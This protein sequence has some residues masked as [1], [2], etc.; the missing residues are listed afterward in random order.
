MRRLRN[1]FAAGALA[2]ALL[3]VM[4]PAA[5]ADTM[6]SRVGVATPMYPAVR[7][8]KSTI[9][10]IYSLTP[11]TAK[12]T[13]QIDGYW[14]KP[15]I[16]MTTMRG[17]APGNLVQQLKSYG[18]FTTCNPRTSNNCVNGPLHI[19]ALVGADEAAVDAV[20]P[21]VDAGTCTASETVECNGT[22]WSKSWLGTGQ[23]AIYSC[24]GSW[25][26]AAKG[27]D[28]S[29]SA[30]PRLAFGSDASG[31]G[32]GRPQSPRCD[33]PPVSGGAPTSIPGVVSWLAASGNR[34]AVADPA[35]DGFGEASKQAL[36]HNGFSWIDSG[37]GQNVF[38]GRACDSAGTACKVR[39]ESGSTQVRG[40]VTA[41]AG[42][43]TQLGLI[44]NSTL[45]NVN[46]TSSSLN[47]TTSH[48]PNTWTV[49]DWSD[50]GSGDIALA[51]FGVALN[52]DSMFEAGYSWGSLFVN[53]W[54][55]YNDIQTTLA[56]YGYV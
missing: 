36:I 51:R 3:A 52:A 6:D 13:P 5:S 15:A 14:N 31:S 7:D 38:R 47:G 8:M 55:Y 30:T 43:N 29:N 16:D 41:N 25:A 42:G 22:G 35:S 24:S 40:A 32:N 10:G 12:T 2:T 37:A 20:I 4:A 9:A 45:M 18:P 17:V 21:T 53:E 56:A 48:D 34:I 26:G 27:A 1:A 44:A 28:P 39:L 19:D 33:A 50:Y 46:W 54:W 11:F 23:L 49:V